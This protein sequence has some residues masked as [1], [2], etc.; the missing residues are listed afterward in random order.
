MIKGFEIEPVPLFEDFHLAP[1]AIIVNTFRGFGP[2]VP[3]LYLF[4]DE[5]AF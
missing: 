1:T 3:L 5:R 4:L 2:E